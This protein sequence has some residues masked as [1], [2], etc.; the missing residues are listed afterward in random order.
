MTPAKQNVYLIGPMG[1]GKTTI[2]NRLAHKLG[3]AFY[4]CDHEIEA[5]CGA[6][7][8]LIF[9]IE[10][11]VGFRARETRMLE[12]LSA[13]EGVLLATGGGAV[14]SGVNRELL[15]KSGL[16]L[17]LRT[18]VEQQLE[19]LRRDRS[20][21]LLRDTDKERTLTEMAEI[22]NPLYESIADLVFPVNNRN[23]DGT[24]S[25]IYQAIRQHLGYAPQEQSH[26]HA[27]P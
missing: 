19:R 11:E 16:V 25:Q 13:R 10:G 4:D 20:R 9:E 12:E 21:P 15:K 6:D 26:D 7:I 14:L 17:Y 23:I 2:G 24:V 8:N 3:L 1:S 22:R 5:R 18:S 27:K